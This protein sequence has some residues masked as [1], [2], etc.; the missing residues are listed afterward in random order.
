MDWRA[1]SRSRSRVGMDWRA[2]SRSRSRPAF[3]HAS[4]VNGGDE[5]HA[6][7]LLAQSVPIPSNMSDPNSQS[8][9]TGTLKPLS[10]AEF[11]QSAG[12][13]AGPSQAP[14]QYPPMSQTDFAALDLFANSAPPDQLQFDDSIRTI[15]ASIAGTSS[16]DFAPNLPGISGPGLYSRTEENFHPQYGFLPRRVRK[17]SFDHTLRPDESDLMPP[18][19]TNP[20]KRQAEASPHRKVGGAG[21]DFP[22][23]NFTFNYPGSYDN[24]YALGNTSSTTTP[25]DDQ[26]AFWGSAPVST[27]P[28]TY[29]S[30]AA[31]LDPATAVEI[32]NQMANQNSDNPLDFQQLMHLYL[33]ANAS[34][35]P[36]T[37]IN[38]SQVLGS[39]PPHLLPNSGTA[40]PTPVNEDS[41]AM[42][43]PAETPI[44]P[45][46]KIVGGRNVD[47]PRPGSAPI[48]SA[49]SPNL[50]AMNGL[51]PF[52]SHHNS[53]N[54][55]TQEDDSE[56]SAAGSI[57][58]PEGTGTMCTNCH[59]T[60]TPLWR[61]D[62]EG[63]PLCNACGLFFVS[64]ARL[65]PRWDRSLRPLQKLHG[66]VRPLSLK[67]DVIKKR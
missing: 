2:Q 34:A 53:S 59:T 15:M 32:A 64:P 9:V 18:P 27:V 10:L 30:P 22:T 3:S 29:G 62:P 51:P 67:T 8:T 28:S 47:F 19:S 25:A 49:S 61:R 45:L 36:F 11:A 1:A 4:L 37:H 21:G 43:S 41:P 17:T 46:P 60:N 48:R 13:G 39:I 54:A 63:L 56:D 52:K 24:L 14:T 66:V 58:H 5:A 38:P 23:S 44:R 57:M 6:H 20:R 7:N 33:N 65:L 31:P 55:A 40:A 35:S 16:R 26:S 12:V 50:H 42:S